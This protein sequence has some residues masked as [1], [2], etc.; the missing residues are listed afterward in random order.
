M[1]KRSLPVEEESSN[2]C[3]LTVDL[4]GVV[5][6]HIDLFDIPTVLRYTAT[7][8]DAMY[9]IR[10]PLIEWLCQLFDTRVIEDDIMENEHYVLTGVSTE[11]LRGDT[12]DAFMRLRRRLYVFIVVSNHDTTHIDVFRRLAKWCHAAASSAAKSPVITHDTDSSQLLDIVR[13]LQLANRVASDLHSVDADPAQ[14][15]KCLCHRLW[16]PP[17]ATLNEDYSSESLLTLANVYVHHRV[18]EGSDVVYK[19]LHE[20]PRVRIIASGLPFDDDTDA[21]SDDIE[22]RV[23]LAIR[24]MT[25]HTDQRAWHN[26]WD[27]G[28]CMR[29]RCGYMYHL[30]RHKCTLT[31]PL[32]SSQLRETVRKDSKSDNYHHIYLSENLLYASWLATPDETNRAIRLI[33]ASERCIEDMMET[34]RHK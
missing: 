22:D 30:L 15:V 9:Y 5:A 10:G 7:H 23:D 29:D 31:Q 26:L 20:D 33:H 17:K 13:I 14:L 3:Y 19:P 21:A 25:S 4:M 34:I 8:K 12:D 18:D 32:A 6:Q 2:Q 28:I 24:D 27:T 16:I 1:A 11:L